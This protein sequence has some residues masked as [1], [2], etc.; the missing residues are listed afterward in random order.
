MVRALT[1]FLLTV[2]ITTPAL[3]DA[4]IEVDGKKLRPHQQEFTLDDGTRV[5]LDVD[6]ELVTTGDKII[7]TLTAFSDAPKQVALDVRLMQTH[8]ALGERVEPPSHQIDREKITLTATPQGGKTE[9]AL[10]LGKARKKLAQLDRFAVYVG[11][12]GLPSPMKADADGAADSGDDMWS[13]NIEAGR[14]ASVDILGW[15]GNSISMKTTAE[16]PVVAGQP[17][18]VAVKVKNTT[19]HKL[20]SAPVV[21]LAVNADTGMPSSDEPDADAVKIEALDGDGETPDE[22]NPN[23]T[24][25]RK[26][27]VTP[28]R[29]LSQITLAVTGTAFDND[30]GPISGGARDVVTFHASAEKVASK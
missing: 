1:T 28:A 8:L 17:F 13:A 6:R 12:H 3:L 27:K 16:G 19:G 15:S 21:E 23:A 10:V 18:V 29:S 7:A 30:I 25:V 2:G 20:P 4:N 22:V 9:F 14:A 11:P 26:F 5:T 24:V